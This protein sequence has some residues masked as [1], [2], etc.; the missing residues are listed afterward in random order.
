MLML[1]KN[2][3]AAYFV[4]INLLIFINN[5]L[6]LNIIYIYKYNFNYN[7][8]YYNYNYILC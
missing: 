3:S 2:G 5:L 8:N 6:L 7:Y 1:K 4:L